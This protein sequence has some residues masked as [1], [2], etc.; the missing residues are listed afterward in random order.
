MSVYV[1][2]P[3]LRQ[4]K[5]NSYCHMMT[6]GDLWELHDFAEEL[7]LRR[8]FQNKPRF[9]HYDISPRKRKL[10]IALGAEEITTE[11]MIKRCSKPIPIVHDAIK[12]SNR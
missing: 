8:Y 7:G 2:Q 11:E 5:F 12:R 4:G 1:D 10:A 3:T 9:P 6:D